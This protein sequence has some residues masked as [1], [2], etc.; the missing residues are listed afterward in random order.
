MVIP[1]VTITVVAIIPVF[2]V[3]TIPVI[4]MMIIPV[5]MMMMIMDRTHRG[6]QAVI[7][8]MQFTETSTG[9]DSSLAEH[10]ICTGCLYSV[11]FGEVYS[12]LHHPL[13]V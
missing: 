4:M 13:Q 3:I 8:A 5:M 1:V 9:S 11:V 10:G 7:N 6:E 2:D 12:A